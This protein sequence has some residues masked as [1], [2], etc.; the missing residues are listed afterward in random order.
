MPLCHRCGERLAGF[1]VGDLASVCRDC[2]TDEDI[3]LMIAWA[4]YLRSRLM[5][6][7]NQGRRRR[8]A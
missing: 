3:E 8:W 4:D 2:L 1:V 7:E 6:C 5:P